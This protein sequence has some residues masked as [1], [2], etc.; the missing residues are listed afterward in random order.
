M[1]ALVGPEV[2]I[3]ATGLAFTGL[4]VSNWTIRMEKAQTKRTFE[5]DDKR[6]AF[7]R[8]VPLSTDIA[9]Q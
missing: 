2:L 1:L 3:P 7:D 5:I 4:L 6:R 8:T 9:A